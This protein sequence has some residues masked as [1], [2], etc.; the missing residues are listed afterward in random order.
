M[1]KRN[2]SQVARARRRIRSRM[3]TQGNSLCPRLVV[4]KSNVH[5]YLQVVD[6]EAGKVIGHFDSRQVKGRLSVALAHEL[7]KKAAQ[8][9]VKMGITQAHFDRAGYQYH[10][11][12][13]ALAEGLREGGVKI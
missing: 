12:V 7:G 13:K 10:G 3:E 6:D 8:A 11:Q 1:N 9:L 4:F 2:L 5:L